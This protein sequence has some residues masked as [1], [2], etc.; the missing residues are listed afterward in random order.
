M[1]SYFIDT[2]SNVSIKNQLKKHFLTHSENKSQTRGTG[3]QP[4]IFRI[5]LCQ[6]HLQTYPCDFSMKIPLSLSFGLKK[7]IMPKYRS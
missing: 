3:F 2:F 4:E 6:K 1:S 5:K 7:T